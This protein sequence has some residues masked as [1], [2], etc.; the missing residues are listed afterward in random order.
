MIEPVIEALASVHQQGWVHT[1][2]H[3]G[4]ISGDG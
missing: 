4:N 1:R 3:P 2:V